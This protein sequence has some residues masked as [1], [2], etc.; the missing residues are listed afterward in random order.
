[1]YSTYVWYDNIILFDNIFDNVHE[2][3][4]YEGAFERGWWEIFVT[5]ACWC[6]EL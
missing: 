4:H 6:W 5:I 3:S 1:M 2:A